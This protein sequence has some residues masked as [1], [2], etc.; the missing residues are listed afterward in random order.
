M[1]CPRCRQELT[2]DTAVCIHCGTSTV[3]VVSVKCP[4]CGED[5]MK[6]ACDATRMGDYSEEITCLQCNRTF[7]A[8][9][10]APFLEGPFRKS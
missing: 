4:H 3:T 8:N 5:K 6:V 1:K 7:F 9:L 2:S 10:P